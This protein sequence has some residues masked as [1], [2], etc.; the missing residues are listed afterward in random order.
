MY[1]IVHNESGKE[2]VVDVNGYDRKE[3]IKQASEQM[4]IDIPYSTL[5]HIQILPII[6]E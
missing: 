1:R 2:A 5:G 6:H 4:G 3:M